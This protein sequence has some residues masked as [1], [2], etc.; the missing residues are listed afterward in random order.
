NVSSATM[1][2][3]EKTSGGGRGPGPNGPP[4]G[5]PNGPGRGAPGRGGPMGNPQGDWDE[6]VVAV[7]RG[8]EGFD[9]A[10][11]GKEIWA[12]NAQ[13]G[14]VSIVDVATKRVTQTL[15]ANV[16]GANRLK[17]TPDGK[18]VLVSTLR[19]PDLAILDAGSRQEVKRL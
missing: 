17:F 10:P 14:T 16:N 9:V 15:A 6:T 2:I 18:L 12:A 19:G 7:G 13:D 3:I 4:P 1:T 11:N 5:T 8:A